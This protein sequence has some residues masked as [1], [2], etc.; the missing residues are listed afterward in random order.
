MTTD[1]RR[2]PSAARS[3]RTRRLGTAVTGVTC[4]VALV[5]L[6][7]VTAQAQGTE[8]HVRYDCTNTRP[9]VGFNWIAPPGVTTFHVVVAGGEGGSYPGETG[10]GGKGAV[11][12]ATITDPQP[13]AYGEIGCDGNTTAG[14][15]YPGGTGG[16]AAGDADRGAS[17]GGATS[18]ASGIND[19]TRIDAHLVAGGGGGG[20]GRGS[21]FGINAGGDGGDAGIR[22]GRT[23]GQPGEA[24]DHGTPGGGFGGGTPEQPTLSCV[25][26]I[27]ADYGQPG[28]D[29]TG[30]GGGGGGGGAGYDI[31]GCGG[32]AGFAVTERGRQV[33]G[34]GGGGQG[35]PSRLVGATITSSSIKA[36]NDGGGYVVITYRS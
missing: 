17:G 2:A 16:Q 5:G 1:L 12:E 14:D 10:R 33:V 20:G 34:S 24:G 31:G 9:G 13:I 15:W 26:P 22:L 21:G 8:R 3:R 4:A 36:T 6:T 18:Y 32:G 11:I 7:S 27:P 35:G 23:E 28:L 30:A 19:R 29:A 25:N